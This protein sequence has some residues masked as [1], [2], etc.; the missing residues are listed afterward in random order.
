MSPNIALVFK[1]GANEFDFPFSFSIEHLA[2]NRE[3]LRRCWELAKSS[4][5]KQANQRHLVSYRI[6][7][8]S[9]A[10]HQAQ[11]TRQSHEILWNKL[12]HR[13]EF[14]SRYSRS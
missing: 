14:P 3:L 10:E 4:T 13:A 11:Y 5:V 8:Q 6:D 2:V 9:F 12:I 1:S 7:F